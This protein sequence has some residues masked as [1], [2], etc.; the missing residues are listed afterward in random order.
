MREG[1]RF[2][3]I[4]PLA[5]AVLGVAVFSTASTARAA[6]IIDGSL[7]SGYGSPLSTQTINT[8][9]GDS[10]IGDGT[11]AGGSELDAAYGVVV[12]TNLDLF[13]SGNL[14]MSSG[15]PN[16]LNI[17]IADGRSG[18]SSLSASGGPLNGTNG[19]TFPAGFSATYAIDVNDFSNTM[20]IDAFDLIA[21]T[22]TFSGGISLLGGVGS[23]SSLAGGI[24]AAGFNNT[25]TG[26]VNGSTGT[27]A[28][29]T[30]ANA[31]TTGFEFQIPLSTL[32]NPALGSSIQ[33]IADINGGNDG[34]L[35]NQFLGG[36]PLT[37]G[38][39]GN[40]GSTNLN[41]IVTP[42]VIA[43]PEPSNAVL[44]GFAGGAFVFLSKRP[45]RPAM[46]S[47]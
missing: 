14:E 35:S 16:H 8:S 29:A 43:V 22:T 41:G 45:R 46:V 4:A 11:S 5:G 37:Y 6:I 30:A 13:I 42:F 9:F 18:Q 21:N 26:G 7:D 12:G 25:N 34:F 20:Y 15:T 1:K 38:N 47:F 31:V 40:P 24:S 10:T 28:N 23:S 17:F 19:L 44:F 39:L 27:T 2:G 32:G 36:L 33:V 3:R